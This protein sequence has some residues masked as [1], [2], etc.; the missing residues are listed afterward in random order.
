MCLFIYNRNVSE[1]SLDIHR[2]ILRYLHTLVYYSWK[3]IF[4]MIERNTD[5][6]KINHVT[7]SFQ[8]STGAT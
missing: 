3:P 5:E 6:T 2:K 7:S 8:S 4:R 1:P